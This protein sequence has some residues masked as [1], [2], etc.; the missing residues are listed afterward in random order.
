M[1]YYFQIGF[2]ILFIIPLS[3]NIIIS[4]IT[5]PFFNNKEFSDLNMEIN[6]LD[7]DKFT[8]NPTLFNT[9]N[10]EWISREYYN[11]EY[12]SSN[13]KLVIQK[14]KAHTANSNLRIK[15]IP[16]IRESKKDL[17]RIYPNFIEIN[18]TKNNDNIYMYNEN[19]FVAAFLSA[20]DYF[21]IEY[22]LNKKVHNTDVSQ[23]NY[24]VEKF[25]NKRNCQ[26]INKWYKAINL[27]NIASSIKTNKATCN[28]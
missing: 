13:K 2:F 15:G 7:L 5:E 1:K 22:Y 3:A 12:S 19:I 16:K 9:F 10:N 18:F 14:I 24:I 8:L 27:V 4:N 23:L 11:T 25:Q 21:V 26:L 28:K 17:K 6:Y 20:D